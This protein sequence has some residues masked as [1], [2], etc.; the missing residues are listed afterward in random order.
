MAVYF[1]FGAKHDG[2]R[3]ALLPTFCPPASW[4]YQ[5]RSGRPMPTVQDTSLVLA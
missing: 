3:M 5:R 4:H 1:I 2:V